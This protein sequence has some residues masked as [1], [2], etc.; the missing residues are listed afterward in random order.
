MAGSCRAALTVQGT[1]GGT[2][3]SEDD[4]DIGTAKYYVIII[5]P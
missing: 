4:G 2:E 3:S 1:D 5:I